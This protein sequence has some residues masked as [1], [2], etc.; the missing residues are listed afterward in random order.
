MADWILLALVGWG[1]YILLRW[2]LTR[3]PTLPWKLLW[4]VMITPPS[5]VVVSKQ[6]FAYDLPAW[7]KLIL[8]FGSY[9][10]VVLLLR[11]AKQQT[12][13][14]PTPSPEAQPSPSAQPSVYP[15]PPTSPAMAAALNHTP[16][17]EVPREHLSGCFPWNVFYLQNVEYR[18]QAIIC[19]GNLRVDA[20]EAYD[21]VRANVE[22]TFGNRFLVVLQEGF[23]GKPFFALVPNPAARR[24]PSTT[25]EQPGLAITLLLCTVYCTLSAGA[26]AA[27]VDPAQLLPLQFVLA[28]QHLLVGLP[29]ALAIVAILGSHELARYWMARRYRIQTSLPYFI[30]IPFAL[31]TFGA[32]VQIKEPV[33]HRKA[34]FDLGVAG[35]L[36]G[37]I[38]ALLML[39]VGLSLSETEIAPPTEPNQPN[40]LIFQTMDPK[41]SLLLGVLA[42]LIMGS[43]L[44]PGYV[45]QLHPLAFAGWLGLLVI[46]LNLM[47][48]GQL[49]GGHIVHAVYGQQV[50]A[51]VGRVTRLLVLLLALTVQ[52]WLLLWALLLFF[53]SSADE[54]TLNDVTEL[55][56]GRDLLGLLI[57]TFLVMIIL[58][59]PPFL[60][61]WLG[62]LN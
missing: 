34:L 46:A 7:L 19:R 24:D 44:V 9:V 33:P 20:S 21:L 36:A 41:F 32:F 12:M 52:P 60:A 57:L 51:N 30:P 16:I 28:P 56:E 50:G 15:I 54:P 27:G 14:A 22:Q 23:A 37:G 3:L 38:V 42:R 58:P 59:L 43:T 25:A 55:N 4:M 1:F 10:V 8:F 48:I 26:F 47:P 31:G 61:E 35:P 29:Y 40:L 17:S 62:L 13:G 45:I 49:D 39:G 18:P 11:R 53:I 5:A 6:V 2:T